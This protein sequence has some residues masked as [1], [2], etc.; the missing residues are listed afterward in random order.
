MIIAY[1]FDLETL[2]IGIY[3]IYTS[4]AIYDIHNSIFLKVK[5]WEHPNYPP[6][7]D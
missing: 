4:V 3:H 6:I 7:G 1:T 2:L 5:Y